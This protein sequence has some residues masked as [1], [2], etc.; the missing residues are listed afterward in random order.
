M[1]FLLILSIGVNAN[2]NSI[3]ANFS[4][5]GVYTFIS[6]YNYYMY[7]NFTG[8]D[9]NGWGTFSNMSVTNNRMEVTN[10]LNGASGAKNFTDFNSMRFDFGYTGSIGTGDPNAYVQI[11]IGSGAGT[12]SLRITNKSPSL[13]YRLLRDSTILLDINSNSDVNI[14]ATR[15]QDGL[16]RLYNST[17]LIGSIT[18]TTFTVFETATATYDETSTSGGTTYFDNI[19]LLVPVDSNQFYVNQLDYNISYNCT[20]VDANA[21]FQVNDSNIESYQFT[22]DSLDK[23][24]SDSYTHPTEG[25]F[26]VKIFSWDS[27]TL[28]TNLLSTTNFISDLNNPIIDINFGSFAT[29]FGTTLLDLNVHQVCFDNISP[30]VFYDLNNETASLNLLNNYYDANSTQIVSSGATSGINNFVGECI[31][32][33]GNTASDT[34]SITISSVCFTL[35]NEEDGN[36]FTTTDLNNNFTAFKAIAYSNGDTF[37]FMSP[38]ADDICYST[39]SDDVIR[40]DM[41]YSTGISIFKE[42][43][44]NLMNTFSDSNSIPVCVA[45]EQSLFTQDFLSSVQ[46]PAIVR[47]TF[48]G[49]YALGDYTKFSLQDALYHSTFTID[50]PYDLFTYDEN[51]LIQL[52]NIDGST[53]STINLDILVLKSKDYIIDIITDSLSI[54][55]DYNN[56]ITFEYVNDKEDNLSSTIQIYDDGAVVFSST[57]T[58]SPNSYSIIWSIVSYDFQGHVL[59]AV[60]TNTK[61]DGSIESENT[62]FTPDA[63]SGIL[64]PGLASIIAVLFFF[65]SFTL[66]A[67]KLG[68]NWFGL[69]VTIITIGILSLSPAVW[70]ITFLQSIFAI[71]GLFT[72]LI[73]KDENIG[74]V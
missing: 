5:Y 61:L 6:D 74:Y 46:K 17:G 25:P 54:Y 53:A 65:F 2:I 44:I 32:L 62:Y 42:F 71:I 47:H 34:N 14:F 19:K 18:D 28:L 15:N 21:V 3:S 50:A 24:I 51:S 73:Y 58:A 70:F 8:N 29:G 59:K 72:F 33:A 35:V 23:N 56:T 68:F 1:G 45:P 30:S 41:N 22:C 40:F 49:C 12:Y 27:N 43:N 10:V 36:P 7:D 48:W 9:A 13:N 63:S 26:T 11:E 39:P 67:P 37:N 38:L 31:D 52:G 66:V 20:S 4:N 60:V 16:F 55:K 69:L 64:D 57:N